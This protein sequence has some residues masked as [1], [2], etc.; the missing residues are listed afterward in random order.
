[1]MKARN[2][3]VLSGRAR[4]RAERARRF[5]RHRARPR[6]TGSSRAARSSRCLTGGLRAS[7]RGREIRVLV[8]RSVHRHCC[9]MHVIVFCLFLHWPISQL[10]PP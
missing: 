6:S 8:E 10:P 3:K 2:E 9:A 7:S 1:M 4:T 5:C